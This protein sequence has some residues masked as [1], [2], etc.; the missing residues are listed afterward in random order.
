VS[1]SESAEISYLP[2]VRVPMRDG[3]E[4]ST[5]ILRPAQDGRFPVLLARTPYGKVNE[6]PSLALTAARQGYVVALQDVRGTGESG[7]TFLP[8]QHEVEDGWDTLDWIASQPYTVPEVGM[9]GASYVG[10]TQIAAA[11]SGHAALKSISPRVCAFNPGVMWDNGS[12]AFPFQMWLVWVSSAVLGQAAFRSSPET[13][14]H[15]LEANS[16]LMDG[17]T[18]GES[19]YTLPLAEYP[20]LGDGELL[21]FS[22][23]LLEDFGKVEGIRNPIPAGWKPSIPTLFLGGW[24]GPFV[25]QVTLLGVLYCLAKVAVMLFTIIRVRASVPR[26]RFDKLMKFCWKLLLPLGLINLAVTV[27]LIAIFNFH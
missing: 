13:L 24:S 23:M 10:F 20:F 18:S 2:D 19:L 4:L 25:N 5:L 22:R 8:M 1:N 6:L 12:G 7:G 16:R 21:P 15:F 17:L 3:V 27:L 9:F 26:V 11:A 14:Q